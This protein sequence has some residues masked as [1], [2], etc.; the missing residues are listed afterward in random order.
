MDITLEHLIESYGYLALIIGTFLEGETI[1]VLGGV[2]AKL[3]YL[4]LP[5][6]IASAFV[7]SLFGDQLLFFLGR[8]R[9]R[10]VLRKFPQWQTRADKVHRIIERHRIPIII[11]FRFVYGIRTITPFALGM[12]RV[13]AIE[14]VALNIVSAALW[15]TTFGSLGYLFGKGMELMLGDIRHY[16]KEILGYLLLMGTA[17]GLLR[18]LI[19]KKQSKHSPPRD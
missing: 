2:A 13:P 15:A 7:G 8:Y 10:W 3:D 12:S 4:K 6:V 14:F 9:G 17:V 16:E 5:W 1:L 19:G 18:F 11:G